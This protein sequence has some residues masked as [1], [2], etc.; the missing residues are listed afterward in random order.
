M[1]CHPGELDPACLIKSMVPPWLRIQG[2]ILFANFWFWLNLKAKPLATHKN[3]GRGLEF[4]FSLDQKLVKWTARGH[5]IL[6]GGSN[7]IEASLSLY[8]LNHV[9]LGSKWIKMKQSLSIGR[10]LMA[11]FLI[12]DELANCVSNWGHI[13]HFYSVADSIKKILHFPI[14]AFKVACLLQNHWW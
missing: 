6:I 2:W 1:I 11:T 7:R 13:C 4:R 14:F 8:K 12:P 9:A 3:M 10:I 5:V